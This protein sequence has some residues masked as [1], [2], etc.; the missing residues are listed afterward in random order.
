M[1]DDLLAYYGF[2]NI[3]KPLGMTSHDVVARVRRLLRQAIGS[4]KVGHAGTL[5]PLATGVLIVCL[6]QA[7]RLSDYAMHGTKQ[8]RAQVTLGIA[9]ETYDAEGDVTSQADAS[10]V[11]LDQIMD[12]L[13]QFIGDIQQLPPIY[14]AIKKEG[15]KLYE[16]ARA[17]KTV[18]LDPRPVT[19]HSIDVLHWQSPRLTVAVTC[20]PGT[21]IR[22]FAHDLGQALGVGAHLS[23][24][25][26]TCSGTF[27]LENA[28]E[29]DALLEDDNWH[30]HIIPPRIALADLPAVHT[31]ADQWQ[32]LVYGRYIERQESDPSEQAFAY[33][34]D[35]QLGAILQQRGNHW[36]PNK[37]LLPQA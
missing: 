11:T 12:I 31:T 27:S 21:Y 37:V 28:V 6:Q 30:E 29:L 13:P 33:T 24:L 25:V 32:E 35:G 16:L 4:K 19:I 17:G 10:A 7:T 2:L 26:R 8:Y 18:E 20:S 15:K 36:K 34:P 14:S 9:T 23:G 22:S 5:D 1:S 3:N